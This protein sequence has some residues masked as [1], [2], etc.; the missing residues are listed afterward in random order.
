M[1]LSP[2]EPASLT[3]A[4]CRAGR[5]WLEWSTRDLADASGVP[6]PAI[7]QFERG[8]LRRIVAERTRAALERHGL[9]FRVPEPIRYT[10]RAGYA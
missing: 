6:V 5:A 9:R 7:E 4:Q 2:R 8:R 3:P 1:L 10:H